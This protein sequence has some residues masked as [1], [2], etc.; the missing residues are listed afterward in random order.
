MKVSW[1]I[2]AL[3]IG[4]SVLTLVLLGSGSH[5]MRSKRCEQ[6]NIVVNSTD[7]NFLIDVESVRSLI[8]ADVQLLGAPMADISLSHIEHLLEQT[9]YVT[10]VNA[11][12]ADERV[13][14]VAIELNSPIAR[15]ISDRHDISF[16]VDQELTKIPVSDHFTARTL[17]IR[18]PFQE[19]YVQPKDTIQDTTL[20]KALPLAQLIAQDTL[21]KAMVS[22][23]VVDEDGYMHLFLQTADLEIVFG[24]VDN[25]AHKLKALTEFMDKVLPVKGWQHYR[26]LIVKYDNQ[27]VAVKY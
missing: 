27:I 20:R 1:R 22:E 7:D 12:R 19:R 24:T 15:V 26:K 10:H 11:Y 25:A 18:G 9:N 17:L 13:I 3:Y 23:I 21:W 14:N 6:V 5:Y 4:L 2:L 16:Y 8:G